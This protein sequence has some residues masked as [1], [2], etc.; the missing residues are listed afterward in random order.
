MEITTYLHKYLA[1][2]GKDSSNSYGGSVYDGNFGSSLDSYGGY[3]YNSLNGYRKNASLFTIF[4]LI[5][6]MVMV[7]YVT[8]IIWSCYRHLRYLELRDRYGNTLADHGQNR[9]FLN[10]FLESLERFQN[11]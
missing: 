3:G 5:L 9:T 8:Y 1:D 2:A 11:N 7:I 6:Q 4:W 10:E